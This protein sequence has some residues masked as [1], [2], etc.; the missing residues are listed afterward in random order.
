MKTQHCFLYLLVSLASCAP[1]HNILTVS[2]VSMTH[3]S[4]AKDHL[5]KPSGRV[6]AEYC[7][8]DKSLASPDDRNVGL[9]DEAV[10]RAQ[11][12]SGA[13]YLSDVSISQKGNCVLVEGMAMK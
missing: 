5:A 2:A 4:T 13:T 3:A 9:I 12:Q 1:R 6:E 10:L 7:G 11:R 8:G